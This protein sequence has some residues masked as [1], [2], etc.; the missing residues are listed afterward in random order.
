MQMFNKK[1]SNITTEENMKSVNTKEGANKETEERWRKI[2]STL[3]ESCT[4]FA[5]Q[6]VFAF[7]MKIILHTLR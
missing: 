5:Q 1:D 4:P 2:V 6:N 3:Y 7:L